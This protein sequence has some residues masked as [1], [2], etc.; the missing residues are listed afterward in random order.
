MNFGVVYV[1]ENKI[2]GKKYVGQTRQSLK[3]RWF[4]HRWYR[5][6]VSDLCMDIRKYGR[7]NFTINIL[8]RC[9]SCLELDISESL[10]IEKLN[11]L[12]PHGYNKSPGKIGSGCL[13]NGQ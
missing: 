9:G 12:T 3:V 7:N 8:D 13:K 1:I 2:T 5:K 4:A 11:T 6:K 10:W